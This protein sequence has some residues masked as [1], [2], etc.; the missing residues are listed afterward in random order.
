MHY[1][2]VLLL[3]TE[4]YYTARKLLGKNFCLYETT[5]P[6]TLLHTHTH[7]YIHTLIHT[8]PILWKAFSV[9]LYKTIANNFPT[10][11]FLPS[12]E[13]AN[14]SI[15]GNFQLEYAKTKF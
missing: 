9:T 7:S 15:I 13:K 8:P 3:Q 12:F 6:H 1:L 4:V 14:I 11:S 2:N 10:S 5:H